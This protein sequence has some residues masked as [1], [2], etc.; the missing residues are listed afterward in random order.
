ML[1]K[2]KPKQSS[3]EERQKTL[4]ELNR[5]K[6]EHEKIGFKFADAYTADE[7]IEMAKVTCVGPNNK[8]YSL[9]VYRK[10]GFS[11]KEI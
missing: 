11:L 10:G 2:K 5:V 9:T 7:Q 3:I 8:V 1:F 6:K 4:D